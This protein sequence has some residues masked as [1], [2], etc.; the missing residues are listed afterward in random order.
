MQAAELI[1]IGALAGVVGG[2]LGV[3]GGLVMI[4]ALVLLLGERFGPGSLHVYKLAAI[5]A[6][7]IVSIPAAIRHARANAVVFRMLWGILPLAVAG[8]AIGVV[9]AG[10]FFGHEQTHLLRR[11]FG[12]FLELVVVVNVY[13][14][15]RS[16]RNERGLTDH[17]P[18]PSRRG[19]I[20]LVVG[21]P[22]GLIAGLLG[23]GG[24]VWNVPAQHLLFGMRLRYAIATSSY[25]VIFVSFVTAIAQSI[26]VNRMP[27][28]NATSG[29]WL[30]LWLA[31][32]ALVGGWCG[33]GLT[34]RLPTRWVRHAFHALL[35]LTGIRLMFY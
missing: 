22:T 13:Q 4:P 12:G 19:L 23:I 3:G 7:I 5:S 1:A 27:G 18:L 9:V 11:I 33:A 6:S 8:V 25:V 15:W 35:V 26:E 2:F 10:T 14:D 34:H 29:W 20:G 30:A 32:G 31:P 28:L 17:C 16:E 21:L 24:G